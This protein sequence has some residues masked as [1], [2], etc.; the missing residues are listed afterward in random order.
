LD[1]YFRA[2]AKNNTFCTS[3]FIVVPKVRLNPPSDEKNVL[4]AS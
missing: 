4:M 2:L 1:S 3:A